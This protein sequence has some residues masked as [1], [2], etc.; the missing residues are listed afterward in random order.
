LLERGREG[1][2]EGEKGRMGE[3]LMIL[4]NIQFKCTTAYYILQIATKIPSS[5]FEETRV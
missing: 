3:D 5:K 2:G 1:E 4:R